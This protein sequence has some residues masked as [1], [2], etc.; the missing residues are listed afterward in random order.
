MVRALPPVVAGDAEAAARAGSLHYTS[1]AEPG[2]A[3]QRRGRGFRYVT[4]AGRAVRDRATLSRIR[5]LA[6]PPAW[7]NVW[8]SDDPD[9]HV[10]AT[11][12]DARGRKQYRY[13]ARW[14][15]VRDDAKYHR[16]GAFCRALPALRARV[17]EDLA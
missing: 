17:A 9:G 13:H 4:A 6:I 16:L 2:I 8:I 7:T 11:G 14:R 15:A 12:R 1:D 5:A 3:R 10:Q